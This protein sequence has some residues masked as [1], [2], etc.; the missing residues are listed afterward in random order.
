[1]KPL[2]PRARPSI[3]MS[4]VGPIPNSL[5]IPEA[6]IP[7][8]GSSA[9]PSPPPSLVSS[10]DPDPLLKDANHFIMEFNGYV[11][12]PVTS[13]YN[14]H[15]L[16]EVFIDRNLSTSTDKEKYQKVGLLGLLC[17][18]Q[19]LA[20]RSASISC[21]IEKEERAIASRLATT[22]TRHKEA[23]KK[24]KDDHVAE[25]SQLK[26]ELKRFE[27]FESRLK[28]LEKEVTK[29]MANLRTFECKIVDVKQREK[30]P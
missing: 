26:E 29:L 21:H 9:R 5:G 7:L 17:A 8:I 20:L 16:N 25:M 18:Q 28:V 10:G 11:G 4:R 1:M 30:M 2:L 23:L 6:A 13:I 24:L 27:P 12:A 15:F 22:D 3:C 19:A 14:R